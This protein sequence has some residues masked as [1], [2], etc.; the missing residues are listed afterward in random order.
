MNQAQTPVAKPE[1]KKKAKGPIRF[2]AIVPFGIIVALIAFYFIVFFDSHLKS[3]I[4]FG[5]TYANG[6]EVNVGSVKTS[7]IKGD[8]AIYDF[9]VTNV[10]N[11]KL[12]T[13]EIGQMH[14]QFLWDALLRMK[15]VVQDASITNL[16]VGT[17]RKYPGRV[18]KKPDPVVEEK[19]DEAKGDALAGATKLLEGS[20]DLSGL[21]SIGN[22]K[23]TAKLN[24]LQA[25]LT[26]KE[27]EWN[28]S[29]AALPTGDDINGLR[30]RIQ[31]AKVGGTNNP[32]EIQQQIQNIDG[33]IKDANDKV[34]K[35]KVAGD[36]LKNGVNHFQNSVN[37][38]NDIVKQDIRDIEGKLKLPSLDTESLSKQFFGEQFMSRVG[39]AKRYMVLARKYMPAK[40]PEDDKL[41]DQ[42][43]PPKRS[44][45][46]TFQ[47]PVTTGY[48][49]FWLK[50]AALSSQAK[51]S[52][53]GGDVK[54]EILDVCSKPSQIG[55][56]T[57]I[58]I[59]GNFPAQGISGVDAK[60]VLDH[61][62]DVAK[63]TLKASVATFPVDQKMLSDSE[64]L[65]F[66]FAK[67]AGSTT[68]DA[69]AVGDE[70][71]FASKTKFQQIDYL[72]AAQNKE[73]DSIIKG[74]VSDVKLVTVDADAKG[75][76]TDMRWNIVSNIASELQKGFEK[77]F[78]AK[79]EEAKVQIQRA[80]DD[81][82]GAQKKQLESQYAAIQNKVNSQVAEKQKEADKVKGMADQKM[83]EAKSQ[84]SNQGQQAVD[85]LKKKL[86]F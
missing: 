45:G 58:N 81:K 29:L 39:Q 56:P 62:G 21:K 73:L 20:V 26:A 9:Q 46:K 40:K 52:P 27:K 64:S 51:D 8:F 68:L 70:L 42:I 67:A 4:E 24:Q 3:A 7:F 16:Q 34:S 36:T 76:L 32:A 31:N 61:T 60:I 53:F 15:F 80:I 25:D 59:S 63:Q 18:T 66:G 10:E 83:N 28:A 13:V 49:L 79:I 57:K 65:K 77:Q 22:L 72:V 85:D 74:A 84:A 44:E 6:A 38:I 41:K 5:A 33:L 30:S 2:E 47:F 37:E 1:K 17:T 78:K 14:F 43:E 23:S 71:A 50:R 82:I 75:T 48:P 55:K 11:P 54:G 19:K 12:N 69:S 86:K 35:V